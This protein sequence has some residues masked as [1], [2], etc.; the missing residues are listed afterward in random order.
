MEAAWEGDGA[1]FGEEV[2]REAEKEED[3]VAS[4]TAEEW[5]RAQEARTCGTEGE[6][7]HAAWARRFGREAR[8][9]RAVGS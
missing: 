3:A 6:S 5:G 2:V 8:R 4:A 9:R 1:G 7:S